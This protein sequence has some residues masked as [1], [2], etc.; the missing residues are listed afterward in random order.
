MRVDVHP[1]LFA[2]V[3]DGPGRRAGAFGDG[4]AGGAAA[5]QRGQPQQNNAPDALQVVLARLL[6]RVKVQ[7]C[8]FIVRYSLKAYLTLTGLG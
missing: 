5:V 4:A 7:Y 8:S 3:C 2:G 6:L 1:K